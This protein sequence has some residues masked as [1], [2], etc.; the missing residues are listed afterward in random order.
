MCP[1]PP[2]SRL[3]VAELLARAGVHRRVGVGVAA[4]LVVVAAH[5]QVQAIALFCMWIS[6]AAVGGQYAV[7]N[8]N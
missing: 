2:P 1:S 7:P 4:H 8:T 6:M 3:G 5:S